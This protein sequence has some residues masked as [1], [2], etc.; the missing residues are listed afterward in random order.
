MSGEVGK[1]V[2]RERCMKSF[3]V[4]LHGNLVMVVL[5]FLW[6]QRVSFSMGYQS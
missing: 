4:M 1:Y 3:Q 5:T 2:R 6:R